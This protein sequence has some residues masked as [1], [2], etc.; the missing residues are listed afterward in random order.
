MVEQQELVIVTTNFQKI[1]PLLNYVP[2][3]S[4]DINVRKELRHKG[5]TASHLLSHNRFHRLYA[6]R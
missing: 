3:N 6:C 5:L 2:N 4:L 1:P